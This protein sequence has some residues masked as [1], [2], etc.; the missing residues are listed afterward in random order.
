MKSKKLINP[1]R[2]NKVIE[3]LNSA[4]IEILEYVS[5]TEVFFLLGYLQ[6]IMM[7]EEDENISSL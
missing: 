6:G 2:I 3:Q 5:K 1:E 7:W 4:P